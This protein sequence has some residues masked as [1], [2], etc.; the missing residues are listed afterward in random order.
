MDEELDEFG[1]PIKKKSVTTDEFGIPI[2]EKPSEPKEVQAEGENGE[3]ESPSAN[4]ASSLDSPQQYRIP[5][6]QELEDYTTNGGVI[7]NSQQLIDDNRK[8]LKEY[9]KQTKVK[10]KEAMDKAVQDS[11]NRQKYPELMKERDSLV[12]Q[13]KSMPIM[14]TGDLDTRVKEIDKII[15]SEPK[16][17]R[18]IRKE[19]LNELDSLIA[20]Q[21]K[22]D[23]RFGANGDY[24]EN[25]GTYDQL[26]KERKLVKKDIDNEN[27][28]L[29]K[30]KSDDT[31]GQSFLK[32]VSFGWYHPE[33]QTLDLSEDI[34][35]E[36]LLSLDNRTRESFIKGGSTYTAP[37][38]K[39][40]ERIVRNA[41]AKVFNKKIEEFTNTKQ[42]L[43]NQLKTAK[44]EQE[45]YKINKELHSL[46]TKTN[47]LLV[48]VGYDKVNNKFNDSFNKIKEGKELDESLKDNGGLDNLST[49]VEG[50]A[51]VAVNGLMSGAGM[52][53]TIGGAFTD[54]DTYSYFDALSDG[55]SQISDVNFMPSS[56]QESG[57][58][59]ID[60][61]LNITPYSAGK[62]IAQMLPFML[63]LALD[64]RK[65][66]VKDIETKLAKLLNPKNAADL[67]ATLRVGAGAYRK[68]LIDNITQAEELGVTGRNKFLLGN[69]LSVAEG[70]FGMIMP[71]HKF[72]SGVKGQ[73]L[74][75]EFAQNLKQAVNKEAATLITKDFIKNNLKELSE[76]ELTFVSQELMKLSMVDNYDSS[77]DSIDAHGELI[78]G[79]LALG[80]V[81]GGVGLKEKIGNTKTGLYEHI[82]TDN[83]KTLTSDIKE[84]IN[85]TKSESLRQQ[86]TESLNHVG[87]IM[88][89]KNKSPKNVSSKQIDLLIEKKHLI[90]EMKSMDDS[91]HPEYKEKIEK[92]NENI[93]KEASL[94]KSEAVNN[95][96]ETKTETKQ[97][98]GKTES[99]EKVGYNV[100]EQLKSHNDNGGST[101]TLDGKNRSGEKG[102]SSVSIFPERSKII[103]GKITEQDISEFKKANKNLLEGNEDVLAIGTWFDKK[104]GKTYLDVSAVTDTDS[105]IKLGKQYNQKAV[106]NLETFKEIDTKGDGTPIKNLKS[107]VDRVSDIRSIIN[108]SNKESTKVQPTE[109][110]GGTIE[111]TGT[112]KSV[113]GDVQSSIKE[114]E[115]I[116]LSDKLG[117]N[118]VNDILNKLDNDLKNF[119]K[120][121]LGINLPVAVARGA[122]KAMKLA[123]GTAKTGLDI[124]SAGMNYIQNTKW[125][126][127]LNKIDK[128]EFHKTGIV[129]KLN[130]VEIEL[131]KG[132]N[133]K[134]PSVKKTIR[135]K[136]GQ[137]DMS[138]KRLISESKLLKDH[139]KALSKGAKE[140]SKHMEKL[141]NNFVDQIREITK[142]LG[143]DMKNSEVDQLIN[144]VKKFNGKNINEIKQEVQNILGK[145]EKRKEKIKY[146]STLK[147]IVK[148]AI[149]VQKKKI[150]HI[151]QN[152]L[153][154][155]RIRPESIPEKHIENYYNVMEAVSKNK[156]VK[157]DVDALYDNLKE[158]IIKDVEARN[159]EREANRLKDPE[160]TSELIVE[161]KKAISKSYDTSLLNDSEKTILKK[162][163]GLD[164]KY[165]ERL[166]AKKLKQ[167]NNDLE[168][169]AKYGYLPNKN[170]S[171]IVI[172][173]EGVEIANEI[174]EKVGDK[175]LH[176][177]SGL[178]QEISRI[179][180]KKD[181][182]V[183][184]MIQRFQN[185][186]LQHTDALIKGIKGT[187]FYTNIVHPISAGLQTATEK[188][189]ETGGKLEVLIK[190]ANIKDKFDFNVKLQLLFRQLEY[191]NNPT[192]K[193]KKVFKIS[194][195]IKATQELF[196]KGKSQYSE[197]SVNT[198]NDIYEQYKN[199]DGEI[200][201][202][203]LENS[204]TPAEKKII[205][206]IKKHLSDTANK[207]RDLDSNMLGENTLL[208]KDYFPR[209]YDSGV[210]Q[211]GSYVDY[212][213]QVFNSSSVKPKAAK[214]RKVNGANA[215]NFTTL[216]HFMSHIKDSNIESHISPSMKRVGITLSE[217]Q[218]S[219]NKSLVKVAMALD[220]TI[221]KLVDVHMSKN[222]YAAKSKN[223]KLIQTVLSKTFNKI[224]MSNTRA[225]IDNI[226]QNV[227][228]LL[229]NADRI[230]AI[231]KSREKMKDISKTLM[232]DYSSTQRERIGGNRAVDFQEG[233]STDLTKAKWSEK[234]PSKRDKAIDLFNKNKISELGDKYAKAYYQI[235]DFSAKFFWDFHFMNAFEKATG[236]EFDANKYKNNADYK[237]K[238]DKVIKQSVAKS[239][240]E[241]SNIYN[242]GAQSE[243]KLKV[244]IGAKN[245]DFKTRINSFMQSFNFNE[246][247]VWWDSLMS[248][249][250]KEGGTIESQQE[251]F[252][253]FMT[254]N[255]RAIAYSYLSTT[256]FNSFATALGLLDD[257]D[258]LE[259]KAI[260][261]AVAQ[262][263]MLIAFG[264]KGSIYN[265]GA[266]YIFENWIHKN[267]VNSKGGKYNGY[268]DSL[269]YTQQERGSLKSHLGTLGAEGQLM[270]TVM[271]VGE[272][273]TKMMM[274]YDKKGTISEDKLIKYK[275]GKIIISTLSQTTGLPIDRAGKQWQNMMSNNLKKRKAAVKKKAKKKK[276]NK[277]AFAF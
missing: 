119:G 43:D 134:D 60:G 129:G 236:E 247:S 202:N 178:V 81:M 172:F 102:V 84:L 175:L 265:M 26:Q 196:D 69:G 258:E 24:L 218:N 40:R 162:L 271:D 179:F 163:K 136:T 33:R 232:N 174:K 147:K 268:E 106:F 42:I 77:I 270:Q 45:K 227:T 155:S 152:I 187:D 31:F 273:A 100:L 37:S 16:S 57:K 62:N 160:D 208:L 39:T 55:A 36:I 205:D 126:K 267:I 243:Q 216:S 183:K 107:E 161:A 255:I 253:T 192:F 47:Q 168:T 220:K 82:T 101:F 112:D 262:H 6:D 164:S 133:T 32:S 61:K 219:N 238:Y 195:H 194:D 90:Q 215:L 99:E 87:D 28:I 224:L 128:D 7:N 94:K 223:D 88:E 206:F 170:I 132:Y 111:Q 251:A 254:V 50:L 193:G 105:A 167:I 212:I 191:N 109:K 54:D 260:K 197:E 138:R 237:I 229:L 18:K 188:T 148:K 117:I 22:K 203:K 242:T 8:A 159:E 3:L 116:D 93:R 80:T 58:L 121:T 86:L 17:Y 52:I 35:E 231:R 145:V 64:A 150:G 235:V 177:S 240:K 275:A 217:L 51:D 182:S 256:L 214:E 127:E 158:D 12:K 131:R 151:G 204:L 181:Q 29:N 228:L 89:A 19:R 114:I 65:G 78:L 83:Y 48:E 144:K 115:K 67:A 59:M 142:G 137:V 171:S 244:Q 10:E 4:T 113:D 15:N 71:E 20:E 173:S 98:K 277:S 110:E 149:K 186:M 141:K 165:I 199:K 38:L 53:A 122:I 135:E 75:K 261:R 56:H 13:M 276:S 68:T 176:V 63:A 200:D 2:K 143:Q 76:E 209:Q 245:R 79:T 30:I 23:Y 96:E 92:I 259:E 184:T 246:N 211:K 222:I 124:T 34:K 249:M 156:Y 85:T 207:R 125:Y 226:S 153:E 166:S 97:G 120:E 190:K 221:N 252:R 72:F 225:V 210:K 272:L 14:S 241:I 230:G 169:L 234:N 9:E 189:L 66:N 201:V 70:V 95:T 123:V 11:M 198:I 130:E 185:K 103:D 46:S 104:S 49:F 264:N 44:T 250:G 27:A 263:G 154:L 248:M 180:G 233:I 118:K 139:F 1:I 239:D 269:L 41:K 157:E 5:T 21:Q 266:A 274:E 140:G 74:K 91:F 108:E 146:N 213:K 257:D 25:N 73:I